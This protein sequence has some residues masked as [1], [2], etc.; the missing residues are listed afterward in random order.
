MSKP[1]TIGILIS[2]GYSV[3][4]IVG[5]QTVFGIQPGTNLHLLWRDLEPV[6]GFPTFPTVPTTSFADCPE[7]LD[8]LA[9]GAIM[10]DV[11]ADPEVIEFFGNAARRAEHV[12][13]VCAGTILA[14]VAGLLDGRRATTNFHILD[15]LPRFGATP[16]E[17]GEVVRDGNIW[18]AGPASG[19]YEAALMVLAELRGVEVARRTE[20]DIEYAPHPP[21]GTGSP[22][23]AGPDL[24]RASREAFA[25][26]SEVCRTVLDRIWKP[27]AT[28]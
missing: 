5:P 11:L 9:V 24:T 18:T 1:L 14:G 19:S 25:P 28:V 4:D 16:V 3:C 17:G 27:P 7:E 21:F 20:L 10:P 23:L 2:P 22:A 8:V 26:F 6:T 15:Q 13:A 12:I